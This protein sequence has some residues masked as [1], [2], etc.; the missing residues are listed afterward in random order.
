MEE[1]RVWVK[2]EGGNDDDNGYVN[3]V[4]WG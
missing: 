1:G 3:E 2:E 4:P